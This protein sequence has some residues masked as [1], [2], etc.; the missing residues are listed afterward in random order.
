MRNA[1]YGWVYYVYTRRASLCSNRKC[2]PP[3]PLFGLLSAPLDLALM[4]FVAVQTARS[5]NLF[6][7]YWNFATDRRDIFQAE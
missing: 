6:T 5:L 4:T 1:Q 7:M 3:L 2:L